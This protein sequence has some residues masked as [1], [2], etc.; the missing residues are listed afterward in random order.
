[1]NDDL[2]TT[3]ETAAILHVVPARV[4]HM[5]ADGRLRGI[6]RGRDWFFAPA[7]VEAARHR[8]QGRPRKTDQPPVTP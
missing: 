2:L 4:R 8:R 5:V 1:M 3:A 7:D 6:K